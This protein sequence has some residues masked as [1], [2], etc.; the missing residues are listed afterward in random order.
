MLAVAQVFVLRH[1]SS[2]R[3]LGP[4]GQWTDDAAAATRLA[5]GPARLWLSR[6]ACEAGAFELVADEAEAA[7]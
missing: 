5:S 4:D 6:F 7:A 1:R 2:E 3:Y